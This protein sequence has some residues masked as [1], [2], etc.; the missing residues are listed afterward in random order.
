[1][2]YRPEIDGLRAVAVIPVILFHAGFSAFSGGFVGV[3]IFFVISG[4]LITTI[5]LNEMREGRFSI[6]NF[7][8]KRARRILP[9]LF[10]VMLVSIPFS[11]FLLVP[12][13]MKD[14]SESLVAVMTFSSN[15]FFW[16][17]EF[18]YWDT[19]SELK[20]L[21]HTWTLAVDEQYYLLFPVFLILMWR[22][23]KRWMFLTLLLVTISSFF[24]SQ[25]GAYHAPSTAFY[26]LPMRIWEIAIGAFISV[27]LLYIKP[28][29]QRQLN[30]VV[31]EMLGWAG[32]LM[33]GYSMAVFDEYTPFPSAYTLIPTIGTV[34]IILFSSPQTMVGRLLSIKPLVAIGLISYSAYLWH[35]PFFAFSRYLVFPEPSAWGF[36]VL[37]VLTLLLAYLS[38]RFV[39]IPFRNRKL[40]GRK[41]I[42]TFS[43]I[44]SLSFIGFGSVGYFLDGFEQRSW[45][46]NLFV[47]K[48][49]PDNRILRQNSWQF[50]TELSGDDNYRVHKNEYDDQLWFTVNDPR[51]KLLLVGNSHSKDLYNVLI[52]SDY[53][54][55]HFQIARYG[56]QVNDI[57]KSPKLFS[58]PNYEASDIV[59]LVS[60]YSE[61][62]LEELESVAEKII[63]DNKKVVIVKNIFE[64][65]YAANRTRA[66]FLLQRGLLQRYRDGE[67][68]SSEIKDDIDEAYYERYTMP[69]NYSY[70]MK[71]DA[72]ISAISKRYST[73]LILDRMDYVCNQEAQRC[74]S[75]NDSFEKYFPDDA[76]HTVEGAVFFGKRVDQVKW[77][78]G[79]VYNAKLGTTN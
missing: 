65:D 38:W 17:E 74:Y 9:V 41:N 40:L 12:E 31:H 11:W 66:D 19:A 35:Q 68:S 22:Y 78:D 24:I 45:Y 76:H 60:R 44:G 23:K 42:F 3:D 4:Y 7:Y 63:S 25:W 70:Y 15:I 53:S 50:L 43:L 47:Q 14:F 36:F 16:Q 49:Q 2:K 55:S 77:L 21:L 79:L 28:T 32:L 39:E 18:S 10:L 29:R 37:T 20:P 64:F 27:Y 52:N 26:W 71:A 67:M 1:M 6:V 75:I 58:S 54:K 62:D 30:K 56:V 8:E 69:T 33:I 59:M 61:D 46:T 5:L 72:V 48:Y 34:L 57:N 51:P 73:V 13:D